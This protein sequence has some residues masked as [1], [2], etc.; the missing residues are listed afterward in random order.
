MPKTLRYNNTIP[1]NIYYNNTKAKK[2]F[3]N[4]TLVWSSSYEKFGTTTLNR[5]AYFNTWQNKR[6]GSSPNYAFICSGYF[7]SHTNNIDITVFNSALTKISV[8]TPTS[9]NSKFFRGCGC[10]YIGNYM[11]IPYLRKFIAY[12][13]SSLTYQ[14]TNDVSYTYMTDD[15]GAGTPS[16]GNI[17]H[18][19]SIVMPPNGSKFTYM[20]TSLTGGYFGSGLYYYDSNITSIS[21]MIVIGN[22][23]YNN[24]S[25]ATTNVKSINASLTITQATTGLSIKRHDGGAESINNHAIFAGGSDGYGVKYNN[26]DIFNTSLTRIVSS[27]LNTAKVNMAVA[28]SKNYAMFVTNGS[29]DIYDTSLTYTNISD[30]DIDGASAG[31]SVG[32]YILFAGG[33]GKEFLSTVQIYSA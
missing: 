13:L 23:A 12:D 1:G 11:L 10:E 3:Y 8:T 9:L 2:V 6:G 30:S 22:I 25:G 17:N 28:H 29:I 20:N 24:D 7:E 14:L 15:E 32:D 18:S 31:V 5:A 4:N 19:L 33:L 27:A 21:D 26:V 16:S